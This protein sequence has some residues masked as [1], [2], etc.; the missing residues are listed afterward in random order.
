MGSGFGGRKLKIHIFRTGPQSAKE[1]KLSGF[2]TPFPSLNVHTKWILQ[3]IPA[4]AVL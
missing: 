1:T 4:T 3:S 2:M